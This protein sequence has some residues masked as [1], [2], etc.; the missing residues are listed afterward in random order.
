[1]P[2]FTASIAGHFFFLTS[3]LGNLFT[4]RLVATFVT[5][6]VPSC[7]RPRGW[8]LH[9]SEGADSLHRRAR[10]SRCW[11]HRSSRRISVS[12]LR[13]RISPRRRRVPPRWRRATA[14]SPTSTVGAVCPSRPVVR[15]RGP[16]DERAG[17]AI[18]STATI[19]AVSPT[20]TSG[21]RTAV[22]ALAIGIHRP[23]VIPVGTAAG[24]RRFLAAVVPAIRVAR[25][26]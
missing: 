24:C 16:L 7:S 11:R 25:P 13:G 4:R 10:E 9:R 23:P 12:S 20:S 14:T 15:T 6:R 22:L 26:R 17:R 21:R 19:V 2:R 8:H 3:P 18:E 1:M 5:R